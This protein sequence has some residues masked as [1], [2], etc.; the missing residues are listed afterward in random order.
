MESWSREAGAAALVKP[1]GRTFAR[2]SVEE[3]IANYQAARALLGKGKCQ[4]LALTSFCDLKIWPA[5]GVVPSRISSSPVETIATRG[6]WL[7]STSAIPWEARSARICGVSGS[8]SRSRVLPLRLGYLLFDQQ[9]IWI[10]RPFEGTPD[11]FSQ[12]SLPFALDWPS[13]SQSVS[14][15]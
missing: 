9:A 2:V 14:A 13:T 10:T 11:T 1:I 5:C 15:A 3:A 6:R 4:Y 7:T 8:P 12:I